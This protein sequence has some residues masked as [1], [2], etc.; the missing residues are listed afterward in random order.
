M[1]FTITR[2]DGKKFGIS[3]P[4]KARFENDVF[5]IEN[6]AGGVILIP[7]SAIISVIIPA[8]ENP[9]IEQYR[10]LMGAAEFKPFTLIRRN[11]SRYEIRDP[12]QV[13]EIPVAADGPVLQIRG[14][15]LV[16]LCEVERIE[17]EE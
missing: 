4:T 14:I 8:P 9:V 3:D 6:D 5:R 1:A 11:G 17:L 10:R 7:L 13:R 15:G 2:I 12:K 16:K